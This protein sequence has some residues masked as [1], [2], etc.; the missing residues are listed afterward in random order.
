MSIMQVR[1]GNAVIPCSRHPSLAPWP[2]PQHRVL[3]TASIRV[4]SQRGIRETTM[5]TL[6]RVG[7]PR[8]DAWQRPNP[9]RTGRY[10]SFRL[11]GMRAAATTAVSRLDC[12]Y[13]LRCYARLCA[14]HL[15]CNGC[16]QVQT[17]MHPPPS[18]T[19]VWHRIYPYSS[20]QH[21]GGSKF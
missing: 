10:P 12:P 21:K 15:L 13:R 5:R 7:K 6:R 1:A 9:A 2:P 11:T 18:S 8:Q 16:G 4:K 14:Y 20:R 17:I 3:T 19:S